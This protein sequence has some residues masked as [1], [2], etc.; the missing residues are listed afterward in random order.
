MSLINPPLLPY[1][2]G[3][4]QVANMSLYFTN[5]SSD[6]DKLLF[7]WCDELKFLN[8]EIKTSPPISY[9]NALDALE[10]GVG[11]TAEEVPW[12][13]Q[14]THHRGLNQHMSQPGGRNGNG[15]GSQGGSSAVVEAH[16]RDLSSARSAVSRGSQGGL[17]THHSSRAIRITRVFISIYSIVFMCYI[18]GCVQIKAQKAPELLLPVGSNVSRPNPPQPPWHLR[19]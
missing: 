1:I 11:D 7:L 14:A 18:S 13:S 17:G 5:N 4:C 6:S 19:F 9:L 12:Q 8:E 10:L 2:L 3:N 15:R 16:T